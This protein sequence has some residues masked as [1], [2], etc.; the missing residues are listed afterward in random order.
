VQSNEQSGF[1]T[2]SRTA[3]EQGDW[4]VELRTR[5]GALLHTENFV[6]R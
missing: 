3:V 2:Y 4:R 1:R 6:V 5:D